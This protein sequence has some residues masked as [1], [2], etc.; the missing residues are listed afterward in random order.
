MRDIADRLMMSEVPADIKTQNTDFYRG[1]AWEAN[2]GLLFL[3]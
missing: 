2:F 1:L 3:P